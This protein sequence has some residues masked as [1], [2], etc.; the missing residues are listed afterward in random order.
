MFITVPPPRPGSP[1]SPQPAV[2]I[3]K[4]WRP[5][6]VPLHVC[7]GVL[8]ELSPVRLVLL[9]D[10]TLQGIVWLGLDQQVPHSLEDS[11]DPGRRLPDVGL[12]HAEADAALAVVGDVGMV[13]ARLE[14]HERGL[15]RVVG[16]QVESQAERAPG[17]WGRGGALQGDL[18][19]VDRGVW[20]KGDGHALGRAGHALAELLDQVSMG[21]MWFEEPVLG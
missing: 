4:A 8:F 16:G 17:V 18:P 3:L 19:G 7:L 5:A 9:G 15:E 11:S 21:A 14:F 2:A 13:D 10:S 6:R 1:T 20:A 12:Q